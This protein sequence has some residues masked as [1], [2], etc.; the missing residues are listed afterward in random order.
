MFEAIN[1]A[2]VK[3]AAGIGGFLI[4]LGAT[5]SGTPPPNEIEPIQTS[6]TSTTEN[7]A[8]DKEVPA[9]KPVTANSSSHQSSVKAI[10]SEKVTTTVTEPE[11]TTASILEIENIKI[12]TTNKEGT[13]IKI[14]WE[15]TKPARS[16]VEFDGETHESNTG[17]GTE[18][19]VSI[20]GLTT[21]HPYKFKVTARTQDSDQIE[22]DVSGSYTPLPNF[23]KYTVEK[24]DIVNDCREFK[25]WDAYSKSV[26]GVELMVAA[27]YERGSSAYK[28]IV[29][30]ANG[31]ARLCESTN[32]RTYRIMGDGI[33]D[34]SI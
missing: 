25:V 26:R 6:S 3:I 10:S 8:P 23:Q 28:T 34:I 20:S 9:S 31:T 30:G 18:H 24:G 2:I 7:P 33:G 15:T 13:V 21:Y 29:T 12:V 1:L 16:R 4:M 11:T 17:I 19:S 27:V 32:A 5:L 22:D 14:S